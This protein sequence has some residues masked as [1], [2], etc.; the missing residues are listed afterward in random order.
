MR[1]RWL[2]KSIADLERISEYLWKSVP[3][4]AEWILQTIYDEARS[5][6]E[7]PYKGRVTDSQEI[8]QITLRDVRYRITYRIKEDAVQILRVRHTSQKPLIH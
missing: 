7:M 6:A 5:L 1:V 2:A 3:A 8:R 4:S